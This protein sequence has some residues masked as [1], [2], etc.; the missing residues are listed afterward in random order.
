[1]ASQLKSSDSGGTVKGVPWAPEK[2]LILR[3]IRVVL[4]SFGSV[5]A[6]HDLDCF[7]GRLSVGTSICV[8]R[9]DWDGLTMN[10]NF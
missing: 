7:G 2:W 5:R 3:A 9:E 8:T 4:I 6:V 10:F 1:M